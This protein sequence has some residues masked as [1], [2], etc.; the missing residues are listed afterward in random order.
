[1]PLG[2]HAVLKNNECSS[3]TVM[4]GKRRI[5]I[6]DDHPV[7]CAG[8]V[9]Y[10]S[11]EP[12]ME[13]CGQASDAKSAMTFLES[14]TPDLAIIDVTLKDSNGIQLIKDI[15]SRFPGIKILVLSVHPESLYAERA[16]RAGAMGYLNKQETGGKVLGAIRAILAGDYFLSPEMTQRMLGKVIGANPALN[17]PA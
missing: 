17:A 1:M 8:L 10:I 16:L 15:K 3:I 9:A 2:V 5:L 7:M 13:V 6:V 11:D 12:D 14:T 4:T